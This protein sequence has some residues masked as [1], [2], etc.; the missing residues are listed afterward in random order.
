M[1][2]KK[3]ILWLLTV[4]TLVIFSLTACTKKEDTITNNESSSLT[5]TVI[6][7]IR[8]ITCGTSEF[9]S[10]LKSEPSLASATFIEKDFS[11]EGVKKYLI[12]NNIKNLPAFIFSSNKFNDNNKMK[13]FMQELPN[14]SF[15]LNIDAGFDPFVERSER[16]FLMVDK[17]IIS[18]IKKSS[19]IL[20]NTEAKI[21]WLEYSDLECPYCAKLHNSWTIEEI[22]QKYGDSLN[23][24]YNHFPLSFH[25]NAAIW[26]Q[27]LECVWSQKGTDAF[28]ALAKKAYAEEN[29]TKSFLIDE[30]VALGVDKEVLEAC[31]KDET[32]KDKVEKEMQVGATVFWITG[33]PGNVV[34]NNETWEYEILSGFVPTE[35]FVDVIDRLLAQ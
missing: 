8:C 12:E 20:W 16:W 5:V 1:I 21:T 19:Y 14:N 3:N 32:M 17:N 10:Q 23:K 13:P 29:S 11:D 31:L 25:K 27:I 30:A 7:D 2:Y 22:T 35:Y 15:L 34:I 9:T 33:T 18:E 26:A 4:F 24:V 6:W 28:Y